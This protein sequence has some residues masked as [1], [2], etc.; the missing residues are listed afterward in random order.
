[1]RALRCYRYYLEPKVTIA[2]PLYRSCRF[3]P[4]VTETLKTFDYPNLE[5]LVS[6]RHH[7]DDAIDRLQATFA[8]D[9]RF[10]FLVAGDRLDWVGHYNLLLREATG[11]YLVW[12]SH[13]DSYSANFV[14]ELVRELKEN[15]DAI[16]AYGRVERISM[17]GERLTYI[18]PKIPDRSR[19]PGALTAYRV[20]MS[21]CLQFHG[22]FRRRWLVDRQLYMRPT[23]QNIAAD[24]L[25]LFTV[26]SIGRTIYTGDCVFW[27]RYYPSSTHKGWDSIMRPRYMWNFA[28]VTCSYLDDFAP[29]RIKRMAG[30]AIA[31]L[32]CGLWQVRLALR[33]W[34]RRI[35][36][37]LY[38]MPKA[39]V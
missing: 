34:V 19:A 25:W 12:V 10:R 16:L 38:A 7:E 27:K 3:L 37:Q 15:P 9:E 24:M 22:L 2:V 29:T 6:D 14:T 8:G 20:A 23:A 17:T 18:V 31:Y 26:A 21:G 39:D 13:D 33:P 32:G 4:I 30:K 1:V 36:P 5:F 35:A 28:R 11:E